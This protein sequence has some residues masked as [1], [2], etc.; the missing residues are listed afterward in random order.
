MAIVQRLD[1][2]RFQVRDEV[3]TA[4]LQLKP[5]RFILSCTCRREG[6]D[7]IRAVLDEFPTLRR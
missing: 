7:H 5:L 3:V 2:Y 4:V 6:C 1:G